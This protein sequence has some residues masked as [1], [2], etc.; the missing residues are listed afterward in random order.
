MRSAIA[1]LR[2]RLHWILFC[3][4]LLI[5]ILA[6]TWEF[7]RVP[8]G[9][10]PDEASI[11]V[12]SNSLLKYGVDRNGMS[13]PVQFIAWGDGQSVPYA[14][15]LMPIIVVAG[16]LS[17]PIVR[18]P[19]MI[20]GIASLPLVYLVGKWT[21]NATLGLLTMFF[22]A[23]SPWH[24]LLSRWALDANL[25]P[26]A[27]LAAF[28]SLLYSSRNVRWFVPACVLL[29]FC[30]YTYATAYAMVPV[31]MILLLLIV[32][33]TRV[34][35]RQNLVL[36]V[37]S[38]IV[39]AA[40]IAAFVLINTARL[41][42]VRVGPITIPRYPVTPRYET[43]TLMQSSD[44]GETWWTNLGAAVDL[45]VTQSDGFVQN[46]VEPFGYFYKITFP[47]ALLGVVLLAR[48]LWKGTHVWESSLLLSWIGASW[49]IAV[50]QPV[51]TNR[52]NVIFIPLLVTMALAVQWLSAHFSV[53]LPL[54]VAG[55]TVAFA[56]FTLTYHGQAYRNAAS[57]E[58]R[59]GILPALQY[60]Q[61]ATAGPIC[62]SEASGQYIYVL[63]LEHPRPATY[64][65]SLHFDNPTSTDRNVVAFGRYA[66][67]LRNCDSS[68]GW[69]YVL[70]TS[71]TPPR[72]GNRYN[73]KF[74]DNYVVYSPKP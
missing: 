7:G 74:F 1:F 70:A 27:F 8:P 4:V 32:W 15:L 2:T 58:F 62:V 12:E 19:M 56:A 38:F 25:L 73:Y 17:P 29:G 13:Y 47:L 14:Y 35:S 33:R 39:V 16:H 72:L 10:N 5:G 24:I 43:Q 34:I 11:A 3:A 52:F 20:L 21:L 41:D 45:L 65:S 69:T 61:A 30:L 66:F 63:Y 60:A 59:A 54:L 31:F 71:D 37:A 68:L 64:L 28:V 51:N 26:F 49:V 42:P 67:G 23:V 6:R 46:T 55:L 22:L 57:G 50:F 53:V 40:P 44:Q 36:G 9:L 48:D 18:L